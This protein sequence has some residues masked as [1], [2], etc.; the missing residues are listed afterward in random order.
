VIAFGVAVLALGVGGFLI[1]SLR[2][3]QW[4]FV[5]TGEVLS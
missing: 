4:P 1:W 2:G 5:R 3:R